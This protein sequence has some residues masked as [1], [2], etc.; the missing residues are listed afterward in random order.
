MRDLDNLYEILGLNFND[1]NVPRK[2]KWRNSYQALRKKERERIEIKPELHLTEY[3]ITFLKN[4]NIR[5]LF[6]F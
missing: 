4:K 1:I 5:E 2:L 6:I 3:L